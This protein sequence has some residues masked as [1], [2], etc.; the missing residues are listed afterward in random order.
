M[1]WNA[2]SQAR[3]ARSQGR[4]PRGRRAWRGG[5]IPATMCGASQG[6]R[7]AH[8]PSGKGAL[9]AR[10]A[11]SN[12]PREEAG[13]V[14][15]AAAGS[16][17]GA[18][19][20]WVRTRRPRGRTRGPAGSGLLF[21][22]RSSPLPSARPQVPDPGSPTAERPVRR[23]QVRAE[24]GSGRLGGR[25]PDAAGVRRAEAALPASAAALPG[26]ARVLRA[27]G[28]LRGVLP[29]AGAAVRQTRLGAASSPAR[30]RRAGVWKLQPWSSPVFPRRPPVVGARKAGGVLPRPRRVPADPGSFSRRLWVAFSLRPWV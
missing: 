10:P 23:T 7:G 24:V 5:D 1:G 13:A 2:L 30:P 8:S 26:T 29:L 19:A 14:G 20:I 16:S 6:A 15:L 22:R 18:S 4:W 12:P 9:G 21:A 11:K 28:S 17:P 25:G 3:V 27:T